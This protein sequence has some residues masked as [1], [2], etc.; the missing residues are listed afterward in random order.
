M[1]KKILVCGCSSGIGEHLFK[2]Y[3]NTEYHTVGLSRTSGDYI[4]DA[5]QPAQVYCAIRD[6]KPDIIINCIGIGGMNSMLTTDYQQY[7][8]I[9]DANLTPA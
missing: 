4:V 7:R 6:S 2:H 8:S 1:H 9:I 5:T 3:K